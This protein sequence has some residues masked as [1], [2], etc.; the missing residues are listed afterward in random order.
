[1][2]QNL[3]LLT[4]GILTFLLISAESCSIEENPKTSADKVEQQRTEIA[5]QESTRQVGH[6]AITWF[7]EKKLL[8]M[9]YEARDNEKLI[10]HAYLVNHMTGKVGQYLGMCLGYGLPYSTQFSNP[11]RIEDTERTGTANN[12]YEDSGEIQIL[13]QPEPN[14][15]FIPEGLSATWLFMLDGEGN[16]HPVYIEPEIIV[17]PFKLH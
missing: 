9:V 6:P 12:K 13:P 8:K 15:L 2:K 7:Q 10:C 14:G 17:S 5:M 16:P 4:L 3:K 11:M 1:M